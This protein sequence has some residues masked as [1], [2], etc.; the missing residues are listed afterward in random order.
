MANL[1]A[2]SGV[3]EPAPGTSAPGGQGPPRPIAF[4][5]TAP[6]GN[7]AV[8]SIVVDGWIDVPENATT[9]YPCVA[10]IFSENSAGVMQIQQ[11]GA[12]GGSLQT[13]GAGSV[14]IGDFNGDGINDIFFPA[15]NEQP[16]AT[17]PSTAIISSP[18]GYTDVTLG[19]AVEDHGSSL[20]PYL[21]KLL[22]LGANGGNS[23]SGFAVYQY[24]DTSKTFD[25]TYTP[26][27]PATIGGES[28]AAADFAKDGNLEAVVSFNEV[29]PGLAWTANNEDV[30]LYDFN[31]L[32]IG[33]YI[34]TL[35]TGWFVIAHP[36]ACRG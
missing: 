32:T 21:G 27:S 3:W 6:L 22:A 14:L 24:N 1:L 7:P 33:N 20:F 31:G 9:P 4:F 2:F 8:S 26:E 25:V 34:K 30:N 5:A 16:F 36:V 13:R 29:G 18:S 15:H 35:S 19:D 28:I 23:P 10:A 11:A 12:F 17:E